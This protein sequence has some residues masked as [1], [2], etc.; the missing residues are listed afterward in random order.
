MF[1]FTINL[2]SIDVIHMTIFIK[3]LQTKNQ[4]ILQ[5][6]RSTRFL[7]VKYKGFKTKVLMI[8]IN[9]V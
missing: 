4:N 7:H 3:F 2:E 6:K 5:Q 1:R 9:K 8:Q